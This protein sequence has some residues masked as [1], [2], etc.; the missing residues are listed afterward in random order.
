[1]D[2]AGEV[3]AEPATSVPVLNASLLL[4]L[5]Q[6]HAEFG[7]KHNDYKRYRQYCSKRLRKLYTLLK[8]QH[9]RGRFQKRELATPEQYSSE[10]HLQVPLVSAERAWA[11]AMELKHQEGELSSK[12]K[13]YL[14]LKLQ[15]AVK[16]ADEL[17]RVA[18]VRCNAKTALEAEAYSAMMAGTLFVEKGVNLNGALLKFQRA[19]MILQELVAGGT[20]EEQ[21]VCRMHLKELEP[22]I[23]FCRYQ[24]ER[25]SA[26]EGAPAPVSP[27]LMALKAKLTLSEASEKDGMDS[28]VGPAMRG[29]SWRGVSYQLTSVKVAEHVAAA[30]ELLASMQDSATA[31][32]R[33]NMYDKAIQ[34]FNDAVLAQGAAANESFTEVDDEAQSL[35]SALKGQKLDLQIRRGRCAIQ[36]AMHRLHLQHLRS[37]C[38]MGAGGLGDHLEPGMP[39]AKARPLKPEDVIRMHE[40]LESLL[41]ELS[42]LANTLPPIQSE[43]LLEECAGLTEATAAGSMLHVASAC[44]H[45][46]KYAAANAAAKEA[47]AKAKVAKTMLEGITGTD[48]VTKE[49]SAI[50][51][52]AAALTSLSVAEFHNASAAVTDALALERMNLESGESRGEANCAWD[53]VAASEQWKAFAGESKG[54]A[55]VY[56]ETVKAIP[57]RPFTLDA[58]LNYVEMPSFSQ[59]YAK[60]GEQRST[61]SRLFGW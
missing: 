56:T 49:V 18:G 2:S 3:G 4:H 31:E 20:V 43:Q 27:N 24:M 13:H 52:Q 33:M 16:W 54:Q 23:R 55:Q 35:M 51:K 42:G 59:F 7:L 32:Q 26:Q 45:R 37:Q 58:A 15:K 8:L 53:L 29:F 57:V 14:G 1:M 17:T 19:Q 39:K 9:G 46:G 38:G 28:S 41:G 40:G 61:L 6:V 21:S 5:R 11:T 30:G 48:E 22:K 12:R 36:T 47:L 25:G 60:T 50:E 34:L 44:L 10:K